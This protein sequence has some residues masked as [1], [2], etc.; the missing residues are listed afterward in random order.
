[1]K[2]LL[3]SLV[4]C[5]IA[6]ALHSLAFPSFLG[7]GW[8]PVLFIAI[9]IFLWRLEQ[10]QGFKT[11]L[12]CVFCFNLGFNFC[13]YYWIPHTLREFG[14]LPYL[15]SII[16][17][18]L[19][20]FIQQPH[21]WVY[22]IWKKLRP[23][24]TWGSGPGVLLSAFIIT[25]LERYVPQQFPTYAGSPW[26]HLAPYLGLAPIL[27]NVGYSFMTYWVSLEAVV[28][29]SRREFRPLVWVS[30]FAFVTVN[31]V[32]PLKI[33]PRVSTMNVRMVQANIG[34]FLKLASED[35]S[36]DSY[37][38][39]SDKYESLSSKEGF[40]PELI[41]WPETAYSETFYGNRTKLHEIFGRI[42]EKTGAE[43]LI[44]GYDEDP[45]RSNFDLVE[46]VYNSSLL[47]SENKLKTGYHKN[48]LLTFG[49]TLPFGPFNRDVAAMV[50]AVSLFARGHGTP[51]METRA[52]H[53][54]VTPICYEILD[55]NF[56]RSLLNEWTNNH[57][58]ANHTNDS[59]YGDTAEPHQHLF[60]SKWRALEFQLPILRST[61]TGI[62]SIIYPDGSESPRLGIGESGTLDVELGISAPQNTTY[63]LYGI[64]PLF[65]LVMVLLVLTIILKR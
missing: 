61:N 50:P 21:W 41:L 15:M 12:L 22:A 44:G 39:I 56:M 60:L 57:F 59:W 25:A 40:T 3:L 36:E 47:L 26:L 34:N 43:M 55:S 8:F 31:A 4:L 27:G 16:L 58:I 5:A 65:A 49:E 19:F 11:T 52:K 6:G 32:M 38:I 9:P 17:G 23:K 51:L 48:M 42:M 45:D 64:F 54:F 13:G 10:A 33:P 14:Q 46:S 24:Y 63:Q 37:R 35:G 53:R 7:G 28:Q 29:L 2:P 18:A 20:T 30:F 62:T 1:M